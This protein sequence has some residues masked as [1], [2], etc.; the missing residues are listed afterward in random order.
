MADKKCFFK[1]C[2]ATVGDCVN[3]KCPCLKCLGK[4]KENCELLHSE[5]KSKI[6][7]LICSNCKNFVLQK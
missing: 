4:N 5:H 1:N 6:Q 2:N 3:S 7:M